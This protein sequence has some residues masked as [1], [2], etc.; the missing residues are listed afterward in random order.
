M[1]PWLLVVCML[2]LGAWHDV[3]A[4]ENVGSLIVDVLAKIKEQYV[5]DID[6]DVLLRGA[7]RGIVSSLD[8]YSVYLDRNEYKEEQI[9][10]SGEFGGIGVELVKSG[11]NIKILNLLDGTPAA[12]SRLSVGDVLV[13][14]DEQKV[15]SMDVEDIVK[16]LRGVAG[17]KVKLR[18]KRGTKYIDVV[19][20]RAVMLKR[21]VALEVIGDDIVHI[22]ISQFS[23]NTAGELHKLWDSFGKNNDIKAIIL[24]LRDNPGGVLSGAIEICDSF[25]NEGEIVSVRDKIP[26]HEE[27]YFAHAGDK[28]QGLL[29]VVLIN[30]YSASASE[31]VAGALQ[32]HN[33]ALVIGERSFGKG[34]V[35]SIVPIENGGVLKITTAL[36]YTPS[37]RVIE[38]TGIVPDISLTMSSEIFTKQGT[39]VT[40]KTDDLLLLRAIDVVHGIMAYDNMR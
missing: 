2:M 27:R 1:Y 33:R 17:T 34:S 32:D 25:M 15:D 22:K 6:E 38:E 39:D 11:K 37:G 16:L 31:I 36:Y 18:I 29:V 21:T 26:G 14:V 9:K 19:L 5:K 7:M 20:K 35:Q 23:E 30:R 13:V 28:F 4:D 40:K 8:S 3:V 10:N 12:K 24:D